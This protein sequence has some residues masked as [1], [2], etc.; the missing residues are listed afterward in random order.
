MILET[1]LRCFVER[2]ALDSTVRFYKALLGGQQ[3]LRFSYPE[4]GLELAAVSSP[5]LSVLVIAGEKDKRAPFEATV[6]T[7]KV[8]NLAQYADLLRANGA[9]ELDPI[10]RTPVGQK[11]RYRHA[12]GLVVEYVEHHS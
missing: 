2:E 3:T 11:M 9:V 1:Y 5:R 12:D 6:L 8:S 4:V 7:I 10:Q